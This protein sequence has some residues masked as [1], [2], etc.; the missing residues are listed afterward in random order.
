MAVDIFKLNNVKSN[1]Q[2][3]YNGCQFLNFT[4]NQ[5]AL[6]FGWEG[7]CLFTATFL[8]SEFLV[9]DFRFKTFG[10]MKTSHTSDNFD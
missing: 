6:R 7:E 3:I 2:E 5:S 9:S 10:T 8:V 1:T 4:R